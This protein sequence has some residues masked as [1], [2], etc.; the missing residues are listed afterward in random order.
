MRFDNLLKNSSIRDSDKKNIRFIL[1]YFQK[2]HDPN[3]ASRSFL[4]Q[5][6][7]GV[8]KTYLAQKLLDILD[9]E[10]IYMGCA[11]YKGVRC[12]SFTDIIDIID[13][14]KQQIVFLDDLNYLFS[15]EDYDV[16]SEDK[17]DFMSLLEIVK[18]NPNKFII[19]TLNNIWDLDER[20]LDRI[21]VKIKFDLPSE[22]N[23]LNYLQKCFKKYLTKPMM[24]YLSNNSIGYNYRDLPELIRRT[25]RLGN[26]RLNMKGL[27]GALK[28]Y[29]PTQLY[30]FDICNVVG[31]DMRDVVG[32]EEASTAV[33]KIIMV[34][35]K[36]ELSSKLGL[37]RSNLLLFHGLAG[38]GKTFMA[39][40]VAGELGYPLISVS[41]QTIFSQID[42]FT[43][44]NDVV[45]LAKRYK[46][47][48]IFI[49]EADKLIGNDPM[50]GD[51]ILMG[52]F[53]S[54]IEGIDA[55]TIKCIF[56]VAVNDV[57]RIGAS[58]RDRF[59]N[60][61]FKLPTYNER[62]LFCK[63]KISEVPVKVHIE[64][65]KFAKMTQKMS[66]RQIERVWN[67]LMYGHMEGRK[68]NDE[69]L[70]KVFKVFRRDVNPMFG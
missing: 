9:K 42:P 48:I 49:D 19:A 43:G 25:Y 33:K 21:E 36:E 45:N 34:N 8:G 18:S 63:R 35:K 66:Y 52:T 51:N 28:T 14:D 4:F 56:I 38:T 46:N 24:V 67:D 70:R 16:S 39:K 11:K 68:V 69:A 57:T 47:C 15:K 10:I 37:K 60:V 40:A 64:Q 55:K 50:A 22:D 1:E 59:V 65:E 41:G 7:A 27:K 17:K 5:G 29:K 2:K 32:K 53:Q 13:N 6:A 12:D 30:G 31:T 54:A 58:L 44:I 61:E 3:L 23:K 26:G 62:L 20:M